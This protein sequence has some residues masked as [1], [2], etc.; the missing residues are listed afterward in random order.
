MINKVLIYMNESDLKPVGGPS[1]YLYNLNL[2]LKKQGIENIKFINSS[3]PTFSIKN[4]IKQKLP[5]YFIKNL[6]SVKLIYDVFNIPKKSIINFNDYNM[7]HFHSTRALYL[8]LKALADYKGLVLLTSHTPKPYHLEL[9]EDKNMF[10]NIRRN[11]FQ[12][13]DHFAFERADYIIFPCEEAEEPYVNNWEDF[14]KIKEKKHKSFKYLLTG[15]KK[16]FETLTKYEIRKKYNIPDNAFIICYVGRHNEVKGY[17]L[18]KEIGK[19]ML[20]FSDEIFFLIAGVERPLTGLNHDRWIEVGWTD[21]PHSII[22]ASDIFV[23]P[24]KETFFDLVM[25]EVLSLG[26]VV[27]ASNTGGNKYFQKFNQK[28]IM[29]FN[30]K[31]EAIAKLKDFIKLPKEERENMALANRKL[32]EEY[33]TLECFLQNY[34]NVLNEIQN[35]R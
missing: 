22:S 15:T 18:L 5:E 1:G 21:D 25:L 10:Y 16:C 28:S 29:Y 9:L 23:L 35:E 19:V 24:N 11:I 27:L 2:A 30:N 31:E 3:N 26:K 34:L 8:N 17:D 12:R 14:V 33:F 13:Y 7:I 20:P 32:Y 6:L 4:S